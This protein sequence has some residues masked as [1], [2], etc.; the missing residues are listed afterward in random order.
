MEKEVKDAIGERELGFMD[1]AI[2]Q[3]R[4]ASDASPMSLNSTYMDDAHGQGFAALDVGEVW[5]LCF[6]IKALNAPARRFL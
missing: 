4:I 3:V 1:L 2:K 6:A 5:L